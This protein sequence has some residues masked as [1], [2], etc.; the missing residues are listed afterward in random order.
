[1]FY[2]IWQCVMAIDENV[3]L[4]IKDGIWNLNVMPVTLKCTMIQ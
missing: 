3:F 4:A 2:P 1:M